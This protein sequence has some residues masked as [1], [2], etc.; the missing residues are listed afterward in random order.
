VP[1]DA[2]PLR[3]LERL[4]GQLEDVHGQV[5]DR[6]DQP[7]AVTQSLLDLRSNHPAVESLPTRANDP[8]KKR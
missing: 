4:D 3:R 1:R 6:Q 2:A 7:R 8:S 5:T